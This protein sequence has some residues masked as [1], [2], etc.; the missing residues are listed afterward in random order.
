[1]SNNLLIVDIKI[2]VIR[3]PL[4]GWRVGLAFGV[5]ALYLKRLVSTP[6]NYATSY[7]WRQEVG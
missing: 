3:I 1:M 6:V 4:L 5:L 7:K 2:F